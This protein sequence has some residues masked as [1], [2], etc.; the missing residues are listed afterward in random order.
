[1]FFERRDGDL[2]CTARVA[3]LVVPATEICDGMQRPD[4][5]SAGR[6]M[7]GERLADGC[8]AETENLGA[9]TG[10]RNHPKLV[11]GRPD[12]PRKVPHEHAE[13][14]AGA[15]V[16]GTLSLGTRT[17]GGKTTGLWSALPPPLPR[18]LVEQA[19][20]RP[21]PQ[22]RLSSEVILGEFGT[23][24][25]ELLETRTYAAYRIRRSIHAQGL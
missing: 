24:A 20:R 3:K 21:S 9:L 6:N 10:D 13:F 22:V 25:Q 16:L 7:T 18:E 14:F 15:A 1:M 8:L 5:E 17:L 23:A 12:R 11:I 19:Q 2:E 4:S